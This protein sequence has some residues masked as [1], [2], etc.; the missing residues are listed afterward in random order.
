MTDHNKRIYFND[1]APRWDAIPRPPDVAERIATFC[2]R[3][4]PPNAGRVL[5]V[6]SGTGLLVPYLLASGSAP[7]LLLETDFA[8]HM[9]EE[10]AL[11]RSGWS[12]TIQPMD[13]ST[14]R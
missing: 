1:L 12:K 11:R 14:S 3:A 5:D 6:G 4:C 7:G 2:R 10:S 8:L 13:P 9:L